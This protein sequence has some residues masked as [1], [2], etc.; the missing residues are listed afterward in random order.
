VAQAFDL[1]VS[2]PRQPGHAFL[3][4]KYARQR[5]QFIPQGAITIMCITFVFVD[6]IWLINGDGSIFINIAQLN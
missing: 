3:S 1:K 6:L 2:L 4:L 5:R